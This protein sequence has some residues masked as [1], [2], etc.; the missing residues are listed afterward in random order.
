MSPR[1][2]LPLVELSEQTK[3]VLAVIISEM[4]DEHPEYIVGRAW[5]DT[6]RVSSGRRLS[7]HIGAAGSLEKIPAARSPERR[8]KRKHGL[9]Q[10]DQEHQHRFV[11][12]TEGDGSACVSLG[13][14]PSRVR[15]LL[16]T[17]RKAP[18]KLNMRVLTHINT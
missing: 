2:R 11:G 15:R 4:R 13:Q 17:R 8:S 16:F 6:E 3:A 5:T 7:A 10:R 18:L 1:V 12:V 9:L 14:E